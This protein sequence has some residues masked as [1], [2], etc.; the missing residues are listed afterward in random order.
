MTKIALVHAVQ[1][2]MPPIEDAFKKLWPEARRTNLLD[3]F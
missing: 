3:D 1:A 2:A